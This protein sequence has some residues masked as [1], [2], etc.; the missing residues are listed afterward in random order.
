MSLQFGGPDDRTACVEN[1]PTSPRLG[2]TG[3]S[4]GESTIPSTSK[5]S[6]HVAFETLGTVDLELEPE[7]ASTL[8]VADEVDDGFSMFL[9]GI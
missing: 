2:S 4:G 5:V 3:V 6:I 7:V 9:P 1:D 8:E